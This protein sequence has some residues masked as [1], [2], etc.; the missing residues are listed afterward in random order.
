MKRTVI[1]YE[2]EPGMWYVQCPALGAHSQ[3]RDYDDALRMIKEACELGLEMGDEP[4]M[5]HDPD[6][7][8][9]TIEIDETAADPKGFRALSVSFSVLTTYL[10][11]KLTVNEN[12]YLVLE[13][14]RMAALSPRDYAQLISLG[15]SP[16]SEYRLVFNLRGVY[17]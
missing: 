4:D 13:Q 1:L 12:G 3:G 15:W 6:I 10:D 7:K 11:Q 14:P 16:D 5:D 8:L 2:D 9:A 17:D